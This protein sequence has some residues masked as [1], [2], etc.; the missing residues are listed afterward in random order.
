M[1]NRLL[2]VTLLL[3]TAIPALTRA[4]DGVIDLT[5]LENYAAQTRPGY[6][7]RNNTTAGNAI[8][9]RGATLG[10][11]L[12][13]DKR[14]SRNNTISCSSCHQQQHAFGDTLTAS[15]G[16]NGTTGRHSMRLINTRFAA[17]TRFF[18]DERAN[19]LEAQTT[20]PV[21]DHV[22][23]GFSGTSGD[24]AFADL[25][26]KLSAIDDY[27]VLFAM[28]FGDKA[29]TETRIQQSLAQFV[30]S[31]QSFDSKYDTGRAAVAND[32]QPFPNFSA[33]EN[34]G[35]QTF[36]NPPNQGGAGCAGCH[37][38]PEFDIDPTSRN[39]GVSGKIGGGTDLTNTRSPSLRDILGPGGEPNGPFMHD[40][41]FATLAQ[42]I[43]HYNVIPANNPDLDNRLRGPGG[44]P[45]RLNL[46]QGQKDNL[47]AFL[48]TLTGTNVYTDERWS[49][50]FNEENQLTL[51]VL[52]PEKVS[53]TD[54]G[55][56]TADICCTAVSG[57]N[58]LL[59]QSTDLQ[60]WT[61]IA[62][63]PLYEQY[64]DAEGELRDN[65]RADKIQRY[66]AVATVSVTVRDVA[67]L[68]R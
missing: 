29:I 28:T 40:A 10:R 32:G 64:R 38:P 67:V 60:S 56:G 57:F 31:I 39:N 63:I 16:V 20:Q 44:Q 2:P 21:R 23:M 7:T 4:G 54:L 17:E 66:Q 45:Q 65:E 30:R 27:R 41:S 13:H 50:P 58:Y 48:R 53:I 34:A 24:P 22:E 26:T 37:Q 8:T 6:I 51:I 62:T 14:L 1:N 15:N 43:N 49:N 18:W 9:D 61:T 33:A 68:E 46:T 12:F 52:P 47:A 35:M 5:Q 3:A 36:L 59:Q 19:T 11:I 55:D 42:V 25:V